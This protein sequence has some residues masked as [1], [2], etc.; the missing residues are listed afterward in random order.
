MVI[1]GRQA[2]PF[3]V[4]KSKQDECSA[5]PRIDAS[6]LASEDSKQ[7][8]VCILSQDSVCSNHFMWLKRG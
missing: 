1:V 2:K 7:T 5:R 6:S 3:D 8:Q 4:N